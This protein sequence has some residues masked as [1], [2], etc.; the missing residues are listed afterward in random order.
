[1]IRMIGDWRRGSAPVRIGNSIGGV[2]RMILAVF[3][4][5]TVEAGSCA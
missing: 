5:A 4:V 3:V 1:M 2:T